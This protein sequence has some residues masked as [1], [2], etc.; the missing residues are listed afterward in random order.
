[1]GKFFTLRRMAAFASIIVAVAVSYDLYDKH[2]NK[3]NG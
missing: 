2:R 3:R 1:M